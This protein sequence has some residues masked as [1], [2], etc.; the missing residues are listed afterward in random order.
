MEDHAKPLEAE[1]LTGGTEPE[2]EQTAEEKK[3]AALER[4]KK[5]EERDAAEEQAAS[6]QADEVSLAGI[7][8]LPMEQ[9]EVTGMLVLTSHAA[10]ALGLENSVNEG[11]DAQVVF[12]VQ[13]ITQMFAFIIDPIRWA[14]IAL[15]SMIC[16][17]SG[18]SILISMYNSMNER[19]HEIAVMRAL[20][21]SRE[22][23]RSIILLESALLAL[24]GGFVGWILGHVG[25]WLLSEQVEQRT[26]VSISLLD[27][28]PK[29]QLAAN[30]SMPAELLIIPAL[31]ALAIIVGFWPALS[32]YRTD[33]A[34]SL[35][36]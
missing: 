16:V 20:G 17:V 31:L 23:V 35:G 34:Q 12:P 6:A 19:R 7:P 1:T 2:E 29:V 14:F 25:C 28:E 32:A 26:G 10:F 36:K 15:T 13:I 3:A 24:A 9:R 21:A 30:L 18:L 8:P 33:V 22:T 4:K 5:R 27:W 11:R